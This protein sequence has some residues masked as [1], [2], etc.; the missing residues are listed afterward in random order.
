[1]DIIELRD[2]CM[3]LPLT[4]EAMPFGDDTLVFK[5]ESKMYALVPLDQFEWVNLKCEPDRA[6]VLREQYPDIIPGWHMNKRHW[7]TIRVNGDLPEE[8]IFQLIK[9]SYMLIVNSLPRAKR[10]SLLEIISA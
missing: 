4:E 3:S 8:F 10:D 7:N 5:V 6:I 1:M 2:Y 9:E